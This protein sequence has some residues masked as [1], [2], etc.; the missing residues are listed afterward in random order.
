MGIRSVPVRDDV[1]KVSLLRFVHRV[2]DEE[3]YDEGGETK[4][5]SVRSPVT[6]LSPNESSPQAKL[7]PR[8]FRGC[9]K[10]E[11]KATQQV[12]Q[13]LLHKDPAKR[14]GVSGLKE[15]QWFTEYKFVED[16]NV[17]NEKWCWEDVLAKKVRSGE[18]V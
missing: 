16:V 2:H 17:A 11:Q 18:Y 3:C 14:L 4:F 9:S 15:H 6:R 12:I 7:P 1:R 10:P 13:G 8:A 5:N